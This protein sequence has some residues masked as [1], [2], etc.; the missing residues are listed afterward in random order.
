MGTASLL[1]NKDS[2]V[3]KQSLSQS[4]TQSIG[5][6]IDII[7]T[8]SVTWSAHKGSKDVTQTQQ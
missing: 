5:Q 8:I 7:I 2:V 4:I 1:E 3:E 6:S